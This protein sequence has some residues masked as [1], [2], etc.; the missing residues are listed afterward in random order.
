MGAANIKLTATCKGTPFFTRLEL[1]GIMAQSQTGKNNPPIIAIKK[2]I[3]LF[4][5]KYL[6]I[7]S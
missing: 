7:A 4:S 6:I 3:I 5:G 2:D 1:T